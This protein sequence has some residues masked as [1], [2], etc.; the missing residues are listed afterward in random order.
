MG[1]IAF[2]VLVFVVVLIA[3][4]AVWVLKQIP[5]VPGIFQTVIW[6]VAL[7]IILVVLLRAVGVLG[8]DIQIPHV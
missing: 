1:F 2:L 8:G 4:F 3:A 5:N 6:G 7:L